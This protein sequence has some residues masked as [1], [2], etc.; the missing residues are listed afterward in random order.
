MPA[1]NGARIPG[2]S[3][4][5]RTLP[6][7]GASGKLQARAAPHV[8][9][10]NGQSLGLP[11]EGRDARAQVEQRPRNAHH[12]IA[13]AM[14]P[15]TGTCVALRLPMPSRIARSVVAFAVL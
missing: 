5:L 12:K 2:D 1:R 7:W 3:S 6:G 13:K 14:K 4:A 11:H 15:R 9:G 8:A 10:R